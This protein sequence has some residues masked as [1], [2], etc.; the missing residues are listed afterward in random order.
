MAA[1][2]WVTAQ[3][4][5]SGLL[6]PFL[7]SSSVYS[8][9]L[10]ISSTSVRTLPFCPVSCLSLHEMSPRY[11]QFSW[12]DLILPILLFSSISMHCSFTYFYLLFSGLLHSFGYIFPIL[13]C[14]LLFFFPR[15]FVKPQPTSLPFYI[16]FSL[17]CF[18]SLPPVQCYKPLSI[19]LQALFQM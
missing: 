11:L 9:H 14:L 6:R 15:L 7:Y 5:L 17:G 18:Q 1:S 12:V 19:V 4:G 2:S 13:S 3:S 16:S 10:L 8:C